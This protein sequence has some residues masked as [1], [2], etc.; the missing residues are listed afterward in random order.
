MV[1]GSASPGAPWGPLRPA[2]TPPE[3]TPW[4]EFSSEVSDGAVQCGSCPLIGS[5][6]ALDVNVVSLSYII[7]EF[8]YYSNM[9]LKWFYHMFLSTLLLFASSSLRILY[10]PRWSDNYPMV[11]KPRRLLTSFCARVSSAG[12]KP[13]HAGQDGRHGHGHFPGA[14]SVLTGANASHS[15]LVCR[16]LDATLRA[17]SGG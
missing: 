3:S 16:A 12:P 17:R 1:V 14:A 8:T 13:A 2:C 15:R 10:H 7:L 9:H 6:S 4:N 11:C 5:A